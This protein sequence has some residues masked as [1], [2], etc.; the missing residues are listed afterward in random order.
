MATGRVHLASLELRSYRNY[1]WFDGELGADVQV[2]AG[3]NAQGKTNLLEAV[4]YL[5]TLRSFRGTAPRELIRFGDEAAVIR[6]RVAGGLGADDLSVTL[7]S[8]GR[9]ATVNGKDPAGIADYLRILPSVKFTPDDILLLKGEGA[10]RRRALDRAVFG[11]AP[12]HFKHLLDYNRALRQKNALLREAGGGPPDREE[13]DAWNRQ[14]ASLGA[15]ILEARL[16]FVER[17][18]PLVAEFFRE[19]A[20]TDLAARLRYRGVVGE[21]TSAADLEALLG[22]ALARRER[23]EITRGYSLV[24]PHRDDLGMEIDGRSVRKYASQ[25]Q[26]RM[27]ALALKIAEIELHRRELGRYPVLLLDD[28]KSELD[29]DR[30]RFLFGFLDRI[31]A[32]I[33]VTSTDFRELDGELTRPRVTWRV[34]QGVARRW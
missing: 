23:E 34:E 18:N 32:Q 26:H 19:I 8:D 4:A 14:V 22:A 9:R 24:G 21:A 12:A 2:I 10:P 3:D 16:A 6:G 5:S 20:G 7:S 33:F 29:R 17:M 25:G 1:R 15:K 30:V 27:F 31:P 28:V 11:L 13:L